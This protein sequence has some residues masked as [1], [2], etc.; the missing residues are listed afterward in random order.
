MQEQ[1]IHRRCVC[2][3]SLECQYIVYIYFIHRLTKVIFPFYCEN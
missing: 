1:Y 2:V 3:S